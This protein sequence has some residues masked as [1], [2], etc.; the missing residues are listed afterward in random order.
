MKV[1]FGVEYDGSHFC[2]WQRQTAGRTVQACV[3][4]ALSRVA[5]EQLKVY[6]AG[7]TDTG[8]HAS[9]QVIHVDTNVRRTPRSWIL[10]ANTNLPPDVSVQWAQTVDE[11]FHARFSATGRTYRYVICNRVSRPGLWARKVSF[12]YRPLDAA[13]MSQAARCL[14]GK[15][16]FSSFRAAGCQAPNAI[17]EVRRIDVRRVSEFVTV[18]IEANA[19]LQHMVRNIV[20]TLLRVGEGRNS[21]DSVGRVLAARDRTEGGITA[22]SDGLYLTG[23]SYPRHFGLPRP[24]Q[25]MGP[26]SLAD[27]GIN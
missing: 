22:P 13:L 7:R 24:V 21:P 14:I 5:N 15:H 26:W 8:V 4:E 2:G 18:T 11:D 19:F 12:V 3:E 1:A 6:C 17:R 9:G 23:V 25:S 10:G 27:S 20:G 16:D